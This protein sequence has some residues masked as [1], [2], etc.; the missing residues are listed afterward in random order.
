MFL[1]NFNIPV[2]IRGYI[3]LLLAYADCKEAF[4]LKF[5]VNRIREIRQKYHY[6]NCV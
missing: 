2:T 4:M 6:Y 1:E 5:V 3:R